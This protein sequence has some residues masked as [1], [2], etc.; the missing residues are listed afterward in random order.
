MMAL[1]ATVRLVQGHKMRNAGIVYSLPLCQ[2]HPQL[3]IVYVPHSP[4]E[5]PCVRLCTGFFSCVGLGT[6]WGMI[7]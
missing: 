4:I 1:C 5:L 7:V 6:G 3:V 2:C